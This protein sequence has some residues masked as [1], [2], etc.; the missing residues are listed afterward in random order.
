MKRE[1]IRVLSVL[2]KRLVGGYTLEQMVSPLWAQRARCG[3]R[4]GVYTSIALSQGSIELGTLSSP[5]C[6]RRT[7]ARGFSL[8][9]VEILCKECEE[10]CRVR[11]S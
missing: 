6:G 11:A 8:L 4:V 2:R 5:L 7:S 3:L 1:M 9:P 10:E